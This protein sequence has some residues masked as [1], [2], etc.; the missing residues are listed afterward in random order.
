M[1]ADVAL[2]TSMVDDLFV[3]AQLDAGEMLLDRLSI[4]FGEL[5][6]GAVE[7]VAPLLLRTMSR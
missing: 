5:V 3:L 1:G 4:D 7:S 6:D 2:L